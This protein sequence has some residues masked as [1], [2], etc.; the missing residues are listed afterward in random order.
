MCRRH[1]RRGWREGDDPTLPPIKM[2]GPDDPISYGRAHNRVREARGP[3]SDHE[4]VDCGTRAD[5]WSFDPERTKHVQHDPRRGYYSGDVEAYEPR[6]YHCHN[7]F[8]GHVEQTMA[9]WLNRIGLREWTPEIEEE[10]A[11]F[12]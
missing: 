9:D 7:I 6:C 11:R 5:Q 10:W 8:D 4:C 3:A 2:A 12:T 1:Y